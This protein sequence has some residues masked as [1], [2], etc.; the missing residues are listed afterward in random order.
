MGLI[1]P[2]S[3]WIERAYVGVFGLLFLVA[4]AQGFLHVRAGRMGLHREWII[5]AFSI[6]LSIATQH[7]IFI[8]ALLVVAEPS[9]EQLKTLSVASFL[10]VFVAHVS[11]AEV[12]I[13]FTQ[14]RGTPGARR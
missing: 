10:V 5:R 1:I 14:A 9:L 4:L 7:L 12:W 11:F 13:R 8:P 6:G 2:F 3:V